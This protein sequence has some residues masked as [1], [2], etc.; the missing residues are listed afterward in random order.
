VDGKIAAFSQAAE[1]ACPRFEE[2]H[3]QPR[4]KRQEF[5]LF[6]SMRHFLFVGKPST[7]TNTSTTTS[8]S[9]A[10]T[11]IVDVLVLVDVDVDGL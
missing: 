11:V 10:K 5:D 4:L 8:T 3:I 7:S 1:T 6:G 2:P 9:T